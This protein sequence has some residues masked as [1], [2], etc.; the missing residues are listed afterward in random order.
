MTTK[1]YPLMPRGTAVWLVENTS[2][3]FQQIADF[4]GLHIYEIKRIADGDVSIHVQST[5]PI[6]NRELTKK[7]IQRCEESSVACLS[8]STQSNKIV[9]IMD[10][11]NSSK[12]KYVSINSRQNKPDAILWL[13]LN[14]PELSTK[15]IKELIGSTNSTIEQ[16]KNKTYWKKDLKPKDPVLY[17]ICTQADLDNA[18]NNMKKQHHIES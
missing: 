4:C 2:L 9:E 7:E 6:S 16:I 18:V 5:S 15:Q 11:F 13:L 10:K 12:H 3:T 1:R 17:N 14:H 8:F